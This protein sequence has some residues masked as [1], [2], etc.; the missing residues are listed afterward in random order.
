MTDETWIRTV[1]SKNVYQ[2]SGTFR[3]D[4]TFQV[5]PNG[6]YAQINSSGIKF[7]DSG[8]AVSNGANLITVNGHIVINGSYNTSN[9]YSEGIRINRSSNGWSVV[10]LGGTQGTLN[11]TGNGVWLVGAY[12]TP[13]NATAAAADI[14]DS[15]FYISYNG[16][17]SAAS[18][19]QGHAA[20]G[21]S[22]RPHL[23][24]NIAPDVN[25]ALKV[26]GGKSWLQG[27]LLI[28]SSDTAGTGSGQNGY[29]S[30]DSGSNNYI[31]FYG[32]YGDGPAGF[33]HTYIGES[34]YG[35]KDTA[36]EKSE[37]LLFKGNDV[38]NTSGPDRIRLFA[39]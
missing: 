17:N 11:G 15:N 24:I 27:P 22:I 12:S 38:N 16:S 36:N 31:A 19:I 32:V 2:D 9:S 1:G 8:T 3:T 10:T 33:N 30:A 23:G 6:Q 35:P 37:L 29:A 20:T 4:G 21:W 18:R 5:G 39:N 25:Y 28:G 34:I 7:G 26:A 14:T 13:A